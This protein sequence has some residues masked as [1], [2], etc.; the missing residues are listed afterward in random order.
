M[1]PKAV[2]K[3]KTIMGKTLGHQ[4]GMVGTGIAYEYNYHFTEAEAVFM[5][6]DRI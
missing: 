2:N 1:W 6:A 3:F 5:Q 4:G